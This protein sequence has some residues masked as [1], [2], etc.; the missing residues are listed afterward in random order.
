MGGEYLPGK[1][2][3]PVDNSFEKFGV[4]VPDHPEGGSVTGEHVV[5]CRHVLHNIGHEMRVL[6]VMRDQHYL[7]VARLSQ[8][9]CC[10]RLWQSV[11]NSQL[12]RRIISRNPDDRLLSLDELTV[13]AHA[14]GS[15]D[16]VAGN[17]QRHDVGLVELSDGAVRLLL[18][19][20]LHD[21]QAKE[22]RPLLQLSSTQLVHFGEL[23][24]VLE[25][26]VRRPDDSESLLGVVLEQIVELCWN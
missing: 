14:D 25:G 22:V 2:L 1:D 15:L 6:R 10:L 3:A 11:G 20:V 12:T 24:S 13:S 19:Q 7:D 4:L 18:D 17:H 23:H 5:I 8:D 21:D 9:A 16:V 26:L